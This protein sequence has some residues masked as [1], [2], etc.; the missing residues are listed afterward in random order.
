[1]PPTCGSDCASG[2]EAYPV[3]QTDGCFAAGRSEGHTTI[4][5]RTFA[6]LLVSTLLTGCGGGDGSGGTTPTPTP[7]PTPTAEVGIHRLISPSVG[8]LTIS[9]PGAAGRPEKITLD[10][11]ETLVLESGTTTKT[12]AGS[13]LQTEAIT[14]ASPAGEV[15]TVAM[16]ICGQT[17]AGSDLLRFYRVRQAP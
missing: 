16:A 5:R 11:D 9:D 2:K 6:T 13:T 17:S 3:H 12:F 10:G 4:D 8:F 14:F 15:W 7:T 1:M